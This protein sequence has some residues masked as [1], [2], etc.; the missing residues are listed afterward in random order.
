VLDP[1]FRDPYRLRWLLALLAALIVSAVALG[2]GYQLVQGIATGEVMDAPGRA[3]SGGWNPEQYHRLA[4]DAGRYFIELTGWAILSALF[5]ALALLAVWLWS[6]AGGFAGSIERLTQNRIERERR[7]ADRVIFAELS[8][9]M[10]AHWSALRFELRRLARGP[11]Q[12]VIV[13]PEGLHHDVVELSP[14]LY[15]QTAV[16]ER[17]F[18]L[19][20]VRFERLSYTLTRKPDGTLQHERGELTL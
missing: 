8:R 5:G 9:V 11:V 1:R 13:S 4:D 15:E 16:L 19:H 20:G 14:A 7:V 18:D 2:A 6:N 12:H 3:R 17:I 10:P